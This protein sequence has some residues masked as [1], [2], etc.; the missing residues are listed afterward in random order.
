MPR[1][2]KVLGGSPLPF[3]VLR[4]AP[5]PIGLVAAM[6]LGYVGQS[7]NRGVNTSTTYT[8]QTVQSGHTADYAGVSVVAWDNNVSQ[9][10]DASAPGPCPHFATE[11]LTRSGTPVTSVYSTVRALSGSYV[12]EVINQQLQ[13]VFTDWLAAGANPDTSR[14]DLIW[15]GGENEANDTTGS[16]ERA[17]RLAYTIPRIG[18]ILF[19][20]WRLGRLHV[21]GLRTDTASYEPLDATV[22][23]SQQQAGTITAGAF[24]IETRSPTALAMADGV[25]IDPDD[26]DGYDLAATYFYNA[27]NAV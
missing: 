26:A 23:A 19:N 20:D 14:V 22:R 15:W 1:V 25:H 27:A 4:G 17:E 2:R 16:L 9:A 5:A 21:M 6:Y 3:T 13:E 10:V 24:Y 12:E 11:L 8:N 7:N 18:R